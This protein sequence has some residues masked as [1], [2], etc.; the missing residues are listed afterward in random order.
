MIA[1]NAVMFAWMSEI[2]RTR[3]HVMV[4]WSENEGKSRM[5]LTPC[6]LGRIR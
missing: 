3:M 4:A 5:S 6:L 1:S 2:T